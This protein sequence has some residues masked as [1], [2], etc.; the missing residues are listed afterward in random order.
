MEGLPFEGI[1][2]VDF[3]HEWAGPIGT[4]VLADFGAEVI[5]VEYVRRL[6]VVRGARTDNQH[7]NHHPM[8]HQV[9]RNKLSITLDLNIPEEKQAFKDLVQVSDLVVNNCRAGVMEKFDLGYEELRKIRPDII[10]ASLSGFGATGPYATYAGFGG[11]IEPISGLMLLTAYQR[12]GKRFRV[13]EMDVVNGLAGTCALVTALVHRQLTG[14][15]QWIDL[16]QTETATHALL[17]E[18]LLEYVMNGTQTLPMGNRHRYFAPQGC[19][20]CAGQDRWVTITVRSEEQWHA[21]CRILKHPE[22]TSDARFYTH[23]A[24]MAHHDELDHHI[25]HWTG[26]RSHIEAMNLLQRSG[27]PAGAVLNEE[28]LRDDPHLN[29]RGYFMTAEDGREGRFPGMLFQ[30]AEGAGR[31]RHRGPDLG[32]HNE[33]VFRGILGRSADEVPTVEEDRIGTGYDPD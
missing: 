31:L 8:W 10:L 27:V 18:H 19:Y 13:R 4:R 16:S 29:A 33:T 21:L 11:T 6:C 15:G 5:K 12:D 23:A 30:L 3:T 1:R 20:R 28:E 7:Y 2:V 14:E 22:W 17:G 9:N 25:E 32:E 24:R 26:Q